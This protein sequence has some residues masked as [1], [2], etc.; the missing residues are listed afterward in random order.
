MIKIR[1]DKFEF[2]AG[3]NAYPCAIMQFYDLSGVYLSLT[4]FDNRWEKQYFELLVEHLK[5]SAS[6]N[7]IMA[8][9]LLLNSQWAIM[10]AKFPF[11][12]NVSN[13]E[14]KHR[15]LSVAL[16]IDLVCGIV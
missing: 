10:S 2:T 1:G 6:S 13:L 4:V 7:L 12:S 9:L 16:S 15:I 5:Y 11:V 3:Q 8:S 14:N